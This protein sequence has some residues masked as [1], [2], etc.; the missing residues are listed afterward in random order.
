M[1]LSYLRNTVEPRDIETENIKV[2]VLFV[3]GKFDSELKT[4]GLICLKACYPKMCISRK[5]IFQ[6]NARIN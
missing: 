4:S 5:I 3:R 1:N 6:T 2:F